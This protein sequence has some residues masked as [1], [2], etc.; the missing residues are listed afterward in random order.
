M[1]VAVAAS[2]R[3]RRG[4]GNSNGLGKA[5]PSGTTSR[6][7]AERRMSNTIRLISTGRASLSGVDAASGS[8][9]TRGLDAT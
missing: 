4:S 7:I 2:T 3:P 8:G 5:E 6:V 1:C 9:I